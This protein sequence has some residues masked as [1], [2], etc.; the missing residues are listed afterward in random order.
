[1]CFFFVT[2]LDSFF[3]MYKIVYMCMYVANHCVIYNSR[4]SN[5]FPNLFDFSMSSS[6][7][8]N[9]HLKTCP[10][11]PQNLL[12]PSYNCKSKGFRMKN[13]WPPPPPPRA[14]KFLSSKKLRRDT[15]AMSN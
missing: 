1:M 12:P 14:F 5:F 10:L 15:P 3:C 4:L 6:A 2:N 9:T 11:T 13:E 8:T 7:V